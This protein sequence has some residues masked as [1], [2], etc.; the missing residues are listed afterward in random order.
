[1]AD[2]PVVGGG[3]GS[4]DDVAHR[5]NQRACSRAAQG[6]TPFSPRSPPP[7]AGPRGR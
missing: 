2:P 6:V 5:G 3:L 7:R 1:M 4:R